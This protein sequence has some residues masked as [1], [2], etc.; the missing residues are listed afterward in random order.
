MRLYFGLICLFILPAFAFEESK[1]V[2]SGT[3]CALG[4]D[5]DA[6]RIKLTELLENNK[7]I[8]LRDGAIVSGRNI[9][10]DKYIIKPSHGPYT[11][12]KVEKIKGD[13]AIGRDMVC[14]EVTGVDPSEFENRYFDC[15]RKD[16][17]SYDKIYSG[18]PIKFKSKND[19]DTHPDAQYPNI[20][21][22]IENN[23]YFYITS[24][25]EKL[26]CSRKVFKSKTAV[27]DCPHRLNDE[28][29]KGKS[30]AGQFYRL[31]LDQNSGAMESQVCNH[32]PKDTSKLDCIYHS[33]AIC[34]EVKKGGSSSSPASESATQ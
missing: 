23:N 29:A 34:K 26:K 18:K 1:W 19:T 10:S 30:E 6:A 31:S 27:L 24:T 11:I 5:E 20:H 15:I 22:N 16:K 25:R 8:F 3:V 12:G 32:N 9:E 21:I 28:P 13:G 7:K 2:Q 33:S 14:A 4:A 17:G